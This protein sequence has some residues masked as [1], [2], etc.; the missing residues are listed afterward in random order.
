[1]TVATTMIDDT[2]RL[3]QAFRASVTRELA[4]LLQA[5]VVPSNAAGAASSSPVALELKFAAERRRT[6]RMARL[7]RTLKRMDDGEFGYCVE[8]GETIDELRLREDVT[9]FLC[10]ACAEFRSH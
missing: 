6:N 10:Q 9:H 4:E 8:C 7:H 5:S 2:D 1:M 3:S